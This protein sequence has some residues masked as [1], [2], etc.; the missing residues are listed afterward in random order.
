[1]VMP[2]GL[3]EKGPQAFAPELKTDT[4][5]LSVSKNHWE[6]KPSDVFTVGCGRRVMSYQ[7]RYEY[8]KNRTYRK[9]K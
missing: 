3:Q 6:E 1:M 9:E 8:L 5:S 7:E 4:E 2:S